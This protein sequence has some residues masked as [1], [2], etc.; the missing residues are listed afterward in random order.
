MQKKLSDNENEVNINKVLKYQEKE[1]DNIKTIDK[2]RMEETISNTENLLNELGY[3]VN[4]INTSLRVIKDKKT[5][6]VP[7][8][9]EMCAEASKYIKEDVDIYMIYLQKM[10]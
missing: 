7:T 4:N 9:N 3:S 10:N 6:V 5:I 2:D 1:L 8:W